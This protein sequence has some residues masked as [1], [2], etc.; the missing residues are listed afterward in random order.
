MGIF[1]ESEGDEGTDLESVLFR[2]LWQFLFSSRSSDSS[3]AASGFD[4]VPDV[5]TALDCSL[6]D[7]RSTCWVGS[8]AVDGEADR[9][10]RRFIVLKSVVVVL[11]AGGNKAIDH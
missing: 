11:F 3:E 5:P 9:S 4:S 2:R 10:R 7:L 8:E 6:A 1:F